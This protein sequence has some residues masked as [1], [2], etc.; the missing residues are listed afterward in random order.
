[1]PSAATSSEAGP[2]KA[3]LGGF[4]TQGLRVKGLGFRVLN[5]KEKPYM[6]KQTR[7]RNTPY[8]TVSPLGRLQIEYTRHIAGYSTES[9]V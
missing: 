5:M 3:G 9:R 8:A 6:R 4:R 2:V 1:M 7:L